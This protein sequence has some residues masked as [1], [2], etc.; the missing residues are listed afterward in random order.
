[1]AD[2]PIS[3]VVPTRDRPA[4]LDRCLASIAASLR[5]HDELVVVDSASTDPE[6]RA[7]AVRHGARYIRCERPGASRARNEG[8]R[9]AAHDVVAFVDDDVRVSSGWA[10][11]LAE[12]F[13]A[14]PDAVFVTGRIGVPPE[15]GLVER[16]VALKDDTEPARIH[17]AS[18]GVL[19]HSA[20]LG[21]RRAALAAIGGFDE[22]LGA[23]ARFRAAE[24][25]D[26]FD[27]LLAAGGDGRYEP[28][29]EAWHEQWRT[30]L[31]LLKLDWAYGIGTGARLR[32][33]WWSDPQ[34][35]RLATRAFLW[36]Y[37]VRR[38]PRAIRNRYKFGVAA[39]L[40]RL[41]G[42]AVGVALALPA[43]VREGRFV[44]RD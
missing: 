42:T 40:A 23:G 12:A 39:I 6:V 10:S 5:P 19:G 27:R 18:T 33:L 7:V 30:R 4:M 15:Q 36:Q 38:L 41:S 25:N 11:A 17:R 26:L 43:R 37:G 28:A 8:W 21:V 16:P 44:V 29:V 2:Q 20:N 13:A 22:A 9:S 14:H 1:M 32:K 31:A 34:R 3:V 35:A 24:D